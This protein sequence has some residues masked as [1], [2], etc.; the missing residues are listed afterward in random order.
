MKIDFDEM[1]PAE[2]K[3]FIRSAEKA[4]QET[5]EARK[6][7]AEDALHD[8]F[9]FLELLGMRL[10]DIYSGE[11]LDEDDFYFEFIYGVEEE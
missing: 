2:I 10:R 8:L 5:E 3:R 9:G 7:K 1:S 11:I 6:K 4:L